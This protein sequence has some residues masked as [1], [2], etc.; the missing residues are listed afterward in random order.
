MA[1]AAAP[2]PPATE[3]RFAP[4]PNER[5]A[6]KRVA[7]FLREHDNE[8]LRL[9]APN[10]DTVEIPRVLLRLFERAVRFL[11]NDQAVQLGGLSQRLTTTEAAALLGMSRTHLVKLLEEGAMQSYRVG[12][13]RRIDRAEVEHFLESRHDAFKRAMDDIAEPQSL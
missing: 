9:T 6:Y 10:G 7:G 8:P 12:S 2:R 5:E 4:S 13:H 3:R 1:V 11:R